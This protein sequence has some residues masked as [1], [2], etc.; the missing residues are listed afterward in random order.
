M[1]KKLMISSTILLI[2]FGLS[3]ISCNGKNESTVKETTK[4]ATDKL[5]VLPIGSD[6]T[7]INPLYANDRVSLTISLVSSK[8]S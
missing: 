8:S 3:F 7:I 6:P 4:A 2:I 5:M 1:N